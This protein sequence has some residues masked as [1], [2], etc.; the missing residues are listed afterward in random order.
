MRFARIC[1]LLVLALLAYGAF[2][3][4]AQRKTICTITINSSNEKEAFQ[5]SLP[6]DKYRF[7]ELVQKGNPNWLKEACR[8]DIQCDALVISGHHDVEQGFFSDN[9]QVAEF[10]SIDAMEH[11]SCSNACTGIFSRVKEDYLF[12]CKRINPHSLPIDA[13]ELVRSFLRE[14]HTPA[15]AE[16]LAR[17][18]AARHDDNNRDRVRRIFRDVPAIYGF[19]AVAPLGPSAASL[20][21]R[22]F[23]LD[24]T[25]SVATGRTSTSLLE[26][27]S[28]H[29]MVAVSGARSGDAVDA[30]RA[31]VCE[32]ADDRM[33]TA[34]RLGFVHRLLD[35]DAAESRLFLERLEK[36]ANSLTADERG[37]P[38]VSAILADIGHDEKARARFLDFAHDANDL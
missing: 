16:R 9:V 25:A 10:L 17:A 7:V 30:F 8:Q 26:R 31:D 4:R 32:F 28:A 29:A 23:Q 11:A 19:S 1:L 27:F 13:A 38:E 21:T 14:G 2:D 3:A 6:P 22:H 20:L 12:G 18:L 24:G 37:S 35:R 33:S 15:D 5:R 34:E 36:I